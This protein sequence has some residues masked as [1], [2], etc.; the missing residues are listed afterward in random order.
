[1]VLEKYLGCIDACSC[2]RA[3]QPEELTRGALEDVLRPGRSSN[4]TMNMNESVLFT[5]CLLR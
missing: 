5:C 2:L 3:A 1:M 4:I